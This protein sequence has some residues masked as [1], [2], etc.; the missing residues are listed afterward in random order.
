MTAF[1]FWQKWLFYSSALLAACA[2]VF[3]FFGN[4]FLFLPYTHALASVFWNTNKMPIQVESFYTFICGP[5]GA[6]ISCAYILL[7]ALAYYPFKRKER[8]SRNTIV[9]A[10]SIWFIFDSFICLHAGVYFQFYI[11]NIISFLQKALPLIFTWSH[12]KKV[13]HA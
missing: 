6:T 5:V 1:I 8:W 11:I 12:F 9:L 10:F 13:H 4:T 3:A 7:A 2:A